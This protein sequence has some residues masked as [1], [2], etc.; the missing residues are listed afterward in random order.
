MGQLPTSQGLRRSRP[1]CRCLNLRTS[2]HWRDSLG[3]WPILQSLCLT[4]QTLATQT[5]RRQE[6]GV[7]VV[8]TTLP[9]NEHHQEAPDEDTCSSLLWCKQANHCP[10]W[11][12]PVWLRGWSPY[13]KMKFTSHPGVF[14]ECGW[15]YKSTTLKCNARKVHSCILHMHWVGYSWR[16]LMECRRSCV[17]FIYLRQLIMKSIFKLNHRNKMFFMIKLQQMVIFRNLSV[18][19]S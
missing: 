12:K 18:L 9:Y 16:P 13:S 15:P 14:S 3:W 8:A 19:S 4:Y 2:L 5:P 17:R 1:Y 6:C 7:P 10:I 11:C